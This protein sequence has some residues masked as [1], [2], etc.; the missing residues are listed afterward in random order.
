MRLSW[1]NP[2][3]SR[4][5]R[6]GKRAQDAA[7]RERAAAAA[8]GAA[9]SDDSGT[10]RRGRILSIVALALVLAAALSIWIAR[11]GRENGGSEPGPA[12]PASSIPMTET[13][14]K[15][16]LLGL[17][18]ADW[19]IIDPLIEKGELPALGALKER[20][21][22]GNMKS[23]KPMLSPLLWTSVATGRPPAEHGIIDFLMKDA[24]T[25]GA[26]PVTS[27]WRK[28]KA[29]WSIFTDLGKPSAFVAWW[30]SWPAEPVLGHMVSDRVAY[31]LFGYEA[32]ASDR[33]GATYPPEYFRDVQPLVVDDAA[34]T[35]EDVREFVKI[36]PGEFRAGRRRVETDPKYA[37]R[38]PVN[39]LT[40]I[41]AST[42][43]Y[44]AIALD[45]LE[46]GQPD[47]LAVYY[48][49]I[50][51]V[52]HRFAHYMPP[53]MGMVTDED[54]ARFR[55]TVFAYYR[56]QDRLLGEILER[57][58]PNSA[59]IVL[60][61][62]G[63]LN[64]TARPRED[65][66]YI[67]GKPG[68]WHRR[69]GVVILDGPAIRPG[70]L[71]TTELLDVAPTALYL[72]GLPV[73]KDMPGRVMQE[74][75]APDFLARYPRRS[76]PS[77]ERVTGTFRPAGDV[78]ADPGVEA[79]FLER[80]RSLGYIGGETGAGV[81]AVAADGGGPSLAE[82]APDG[83]ALVTGYLN[84]ASILLKNKEYARAEDL[85]AK[86]LRSAPDFAPGLILASQ[87]YGE[88]KRYGPAVDALRRVV[89]TDPVGEKQA[90]SPLA[91]LYADAGRASE[92]LALFRRMAAANPRLAEI[93]ASI[94]SILLRQ[95]KVEEAERDLL[96]ALRLD[97]SLGGPLTE[98]HEI[99]RGTPKV[100]ALEPI[101][102]E[103]LARNDKSVVHQNWMGIIHEW[104]REL[105]QA[106]AAFLRA[107]ELD[108]DYA[109]TMANLGALYGRTGRLEE[110]VTILRRAVEKEPE[111]KES[112]INLGAALGRLRRPAEAI[113]AL[114]TA[115]EKGVRTTTLFNALA[116]AYLETRQPEKARRFLR[117]SLEI[118]PNQQDARDLLNEMD[119]PS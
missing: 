75:I 115:R 34:I 48:Q 40:K 84:E 27:R 28:T 54:Y 26:V 14:T 65:P 25:G 71:D 94:G 97:P 93:R 43:T 72:A 11:R 101:V 88:Q 108:P 8:G 15:V 113:V 90:F 112:W 60:S 21:A 96:A 32:G 103:G 52:C 30:A 102:R 116:L 9:P 38:E 23:M 3:S 119:R 56:Y 33:A 106:E 7:A 76:I 66:P 62:H 111:N 69:Y 98:L 68:L 36:T 31:S 110:A 17:D 20:G 4:S 13:L 80:L 6:K 50:D 100:L 114:E 85:I 92:G 5:K 37:Y 10:R 58:D 39:H 67:E 12:I 57:L 29:L 51:E 70:R 2:M 77:Y 45:L 107:M 99:Y 59:V 79:E 64:G 86:V 35:Y 61:D 49:G 73:P 109:A 41:L 95:G 16:V 1:P 104:K 78:I 44:H 117:E 47:L 24:R 105:P 81:G 19:E 82:S 89:E 18:G 63:F 118:D 55:D 22:W 74:A 42:R 91:K 53:K 83:E 87:I 46:R